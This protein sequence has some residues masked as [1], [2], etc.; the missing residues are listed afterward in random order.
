[1]SFVRGETEMRSH[2]AVALALLVGVG[3]GAAAVQGLHAQAKPPAY[4]IF[5]INLQQPDEYFAEFVPLAE[6]AV[7]E[8]GGKFLARTGPAAVIDGPA[9]RRA[10]VIAFDNVDQARASFRTDAYKEARK[11]GEKYASFR[12]Y[13]VEGLSQ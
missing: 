2:Y 4:V 3:T 8:A 5:E 10:A 11:V 13:A 6:K 12:V 7:A 9:P 1:V